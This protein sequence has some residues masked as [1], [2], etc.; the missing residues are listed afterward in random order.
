M[1]SRTCKNFIME[2]LESVDAQV[3]YC[4]SMMNVYRDNQEVYNYWYGRQDSYIAIHDRIEKYLG[5]DVD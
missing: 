1:N 5:R 4:E 3:K 2:M